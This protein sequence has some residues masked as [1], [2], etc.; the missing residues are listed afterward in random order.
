MEANTIFIIKLLNITKDDAGQSREKI[1]SENHRR[2]TNTV[3]IFMI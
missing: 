2:V 1:K 3:F